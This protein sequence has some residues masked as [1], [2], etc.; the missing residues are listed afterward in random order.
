MKNKYRIILLFLIIVL[1]IFFIILNFYVLSEKKYLKKEIIDD[2]KRISDDRGRFF[3]LLLNE[4]DSYPDNEQVMVDYKKEIKFLFFGDLML[5]RNVKNKIDKYGL[6]YLL[7][8]LKSDNFTESYDIVAC[9]LEGAVSDGGQH[10]RPDNLYDFA[11]APK[12]ISQLKKYNF[13][14][15]SVAN[16]HLSD[17]GSKGIQKFKFRKFLLFWLS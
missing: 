1:S 8:K 13:N 10:Y 12:L 9:N 6:D 5:D 16:N 3:N 4:N 11:F 2:F 17:Q 15:L 14:Y 7:D